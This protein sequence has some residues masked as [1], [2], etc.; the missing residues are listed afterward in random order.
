MKVP[1]MEGTS[2][3]ELLKVEFNKSK[4]LVKEFITIGYNIYYSPTSV[5]YF[6]IEDNGTIFIKEKLPI[7]NC[8]YYLQVTA[9]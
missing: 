1:E 6:D 8:Y 5:E 3:T 7:D 2:G 9:L 4:R